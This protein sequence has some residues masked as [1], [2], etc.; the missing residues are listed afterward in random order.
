MAVDFFLKLDGIQG[1]SVD[2]N[3]SNEIAIM[4]L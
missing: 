4:S 2:S 3:H 1:E